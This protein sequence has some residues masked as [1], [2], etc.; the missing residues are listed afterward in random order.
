MCLAFSHVHHNNKE[1]Q[2]IFFFL[3]QYRLCWISF[4]NDFSVVFL[5]LNCWGLHLCNIYLLIHS[6]LVCSVVMR[7]LKGRCCSCALFSST[8]FSNHTLLCRENSLSAEET[9]RGIGFFL[10]VTICNIQNGLP[11]R[12]LENVNLILSASF[13]VV[14]SLALVFELMRLYICF[15][16]VRR[17]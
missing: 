2:D 15:D 13:S 12:T 16:S 17:F 7:M 5:I 10:R 9:N 4:C 11:K 6:Q 8:S 3:F 1:K 14:F